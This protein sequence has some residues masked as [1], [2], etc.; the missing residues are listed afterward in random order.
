MILQ[1]QNFNN[2]LPR[3]DFHDNQQH[4]DICMSSLCCNNDHRFDTVDFD[5]NSY[6][7]EEKFTVKTIH[8]SSIDTTIITLIA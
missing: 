5:M 3:N 2:N 4:I 1:F 8:Q 6:L 7:K